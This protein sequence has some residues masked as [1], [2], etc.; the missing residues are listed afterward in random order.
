MH[1]ILTM[2]FCSASASIA[3]A[4]EQAV[5][6]EQEQ[7]TLRNIVDG[8][9]SPE[10]IYG[11]NPL[12]DGVSYSQLSSD[13]KQITRSSFRTGKQTGVIFDVSNVR[14]EVNLDRI[15]G[16]IMSPDEKKIL[17]KTQT[18]KIYRRT[19]TAVYYISDVASRIMVPLS[20][21]GPQTSPLFSPDG[22]VIAFARDNNLFVVKLLFN[23][24]ETQVTKDGKRNEIINGIPD[25]VNEEELSWATALCFTADG[26]QI[27]WI[28]YDEKDV[29]TY[30]LQTF[31]GMKP[32]KPENADYPGEYSYKYPKAGHANSRVSA[33]SYDIKSRKSGRLDVPVD[34]GGYIC[35]M[36]PTKDASRVLFM[37]LNRHQDNMRIYDVNPRS[38]IARMIISEEVD[39]YVIEAAY[40]NIHIT[41]NNI[42]MLSDRDG[43]RHLYLYN[44]NGILKRSVCPASTDITAVYGYDEK[45]GDIFYQAAP[46]PMTRHIFVQ[47]ANGKTQ[48]LSQREGVN[49]ARFSASLQYY[50]NT[51]SDRNTPY[52]CTSN[53]RDGKVI[54]TLEDNKDLRERLAAYDIPE[55]ELF[56]FTTS[57]GVKLNGY[58]MKP[59]GFNPSNRYP[60]IMHQY[61]G[62]ASQ[63][64]SMLTRIHRRCR[65]R[66]GNRWPRR[67]IREVYIPQSRCARV[68][69]PG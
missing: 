1:K 59:V 40:D 15:D 63:R 51:W 12:N 62:P 47:H 8:K 54:S 33:W 11:V 26:S 10:Y 17:I 38:T 22:N 58:M 27:C 34:A 32:E 30:T 25:W 28:K 49:D 53:S 42:L 65:R 45:T 55:R 16:Y 61:S 3:A 57:E 5:S 19:D 23:N 68:E 35:R 36:F 41:A 7:F 18:K 39:K 9:Y 60:V 56:S 13:G 52:V 69:G 44:M 64:L 24:A 66:Q 20:E 6:D 46:T 67:G 21:G 2:A 14:S 48:R 31:K 43:Y 37:T 29:E 4:P 50:F